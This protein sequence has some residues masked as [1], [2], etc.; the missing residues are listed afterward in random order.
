MV[1]RGFSIWAAICI[2]ILLLL[3][4][5]YKIRQVLNDKPCCYPR[6]ASY[7]GLFMEEMSE[8]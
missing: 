2:R 4:F 7:K 8:P 6:V 1:K 3:G 5:G